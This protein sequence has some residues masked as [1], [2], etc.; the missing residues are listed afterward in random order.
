MLEIPC[1]NTEERSQFATRVANY[2]TVKF[3]RNHR[4]VDDPGATAAEGNAPTDIALAQSDIPTGRHAVPGALSVSWRTGTD[5]SFENPPRREFHPHRT[6][7]TAD[8]TW[9]TNRHR[10]PQGLRIVRS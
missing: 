6:G 10:G 3:Q 5:E 9:T 2:V 7:R 1:W 4:R 8:K